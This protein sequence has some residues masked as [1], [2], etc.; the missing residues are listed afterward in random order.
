MYNIMFLHKEQR[1]QYLY[2]ESFDQT[3]GKPLKIVHLY[4]LIQIDAEHLK[5]DD[6]VLPEHELV[7]FA[8]DVLFVLWVGFIKGFD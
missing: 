2:R 1:D 7:Q 4:E 3:Q 6:Q 8:D 5:C